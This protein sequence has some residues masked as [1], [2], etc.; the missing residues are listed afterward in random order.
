MEAKTVYKGV[1]SLFSYPN[2]YQLKNQFVF[3]W[4]SDFLCQTSS[5]YFVEVEVKVSVADYKKDFQKQKHKLFERLHA[6]KT[7]FVENLGSDSY[8][9]DIICKFKTGELKINKPNYRNRHWFYNTWMVHR[10]VELRAGCTRIKI[11]DLRTEKIP[12]RF[13]F[14]VPEGMNVTV[15]AYAG[16][17]RVS[18]HGNAIIEK[19]APF[20]HKNPLQ[21]SH[22]LLDK[23]YHKFGHMLTEMD[24]RTEYFKAQD[25]LIETN[26]RLAQLENE[27]NTLKE[28]HS[29]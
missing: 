3:A 7:H 19:Q 25:K 27:I 18:E 21:L 4:E 14:A 5:G 26:F 12:H 2:K 10:I 16:L 6:K 20:I 9:G 23:Y 28:M 8:S 24:Y 1:L 15:P 13:Y 22:I 11:H 17:I 29:A